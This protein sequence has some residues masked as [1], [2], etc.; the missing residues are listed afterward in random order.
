MLILLAC[1]GAVFAMIVIYEYGYFF[2]G[3]I[4]GGLPASE[5]KVQLG[6]Y[7]QHVALGEITMLKI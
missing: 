1:S 4:A 2:A 7:P 3:V 5:M 6:C